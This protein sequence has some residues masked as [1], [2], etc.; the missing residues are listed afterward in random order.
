MMYIYNYIYIYFKVWIDRCIYDYLC[1]W[2]IL[3]GLGYIGDGAQLLLV[4]W[5]YQKLAIKYSSLFPEPTNGRWRPKYVTQVGRRESPR[6]PI[7]ISRHP[8]A[9]NKAR[10]GH[11]QSMRRLEHSWEMIVFNSL[12]FEGD[13][14]QKHHKL[15]NSSIGVTSAELHGKN[16][17]NTLSNQ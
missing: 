3:D 12:W 6:P 16:L 13:H 8:N 1:I 4:P 5:L 17:A 14:Y 15:D 2:T 9:V 11:V 7:P 10:M